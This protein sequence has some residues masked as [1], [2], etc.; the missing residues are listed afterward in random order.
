MRVIS[1]AV[2]E[3][4]SASRQL[5]SVPTALPFRKFETHS[6]AYIGIYYAP[7]ILTPGVVVKCSRDALFLK[8]VNAETQFLYFFCMSSS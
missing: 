5:M 2:T 8:I 7:K 6:V 3:Y 4:V 1:V